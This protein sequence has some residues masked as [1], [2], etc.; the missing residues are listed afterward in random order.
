MDTL[1]YIGAGA[2]CIPL[3]LMDSIKTFV[4]VDSQP[5]SEHGTLEFTTGVYYRKDF[6]SQLDTLL[7]RLGYT[8]FKKNI[9]YLEYKNPRDQVLKYYINM[10]FPEHL[11]DEVRGHLERAENLMLAGFNPDKS[12]L[13]LMPNLKTIYC[14]DC[15]VYDVSDEEDDEED[16][17][18]VFRELVNTG[19]K[20][21]YFLIK[22][23][24]YFEYWI[25][26][27]IRSDVKSKYAIECVNGLANYYLSRP[28]S[29]QPSQ[30][31]C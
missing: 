21:R 29:K 16:R 28:R 18:G 23:L 4:Y 22:H 27:N 12:C 10:P 17:R 31:V 8:N 20:Y 30:S 25:D 13:I 2:D 1:V 14:N 3:I 9:D 11:T 5:N 15:T 24:E 6:L 26:E 7:Q 19:L